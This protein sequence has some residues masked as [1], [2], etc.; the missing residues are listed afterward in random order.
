MLLALP[1]HTHGSSITTP[2]Q[3][4]NYHHYAAIIL[5][6]GT[7]G[8]ILVT[9]GSHLLPPGPEYCSRRV[10][11]WSVFWLLTGN[12]RVVYIKGIGIITRGQTSL[13]AY[14]KLILFPYK[15]VSYSSPDY[16][17]AGERLNKISRP[18][19]GNQCIRG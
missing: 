10:F 6:L 16:M 11:P 13:K 8:K 1:L 15:D 3:H 5:E 17:G 7:V 19:R 12:I 2:E 18:Y 9:A 4:R 14:L